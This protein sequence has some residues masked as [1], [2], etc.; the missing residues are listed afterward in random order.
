MTFDAWF[1]ALTWGSLLFV[2]IPYNYLRYRRNIRIA[3]I[4]RRAHLFSC[5]Y[6]MLKELKDVH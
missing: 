3:K 1:A 4:K 5:K 2:W 6:R